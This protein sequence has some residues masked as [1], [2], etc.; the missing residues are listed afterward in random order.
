M[1][2][3]TREIIGYEIRD[4]KTGERVKNGNYSYAKRRVARN[5]AE[6]MNMTYGAHRYSAV[7]IF[8]IVVSESAE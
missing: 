1:A 8:S 2:T 6:R 5:R 4:G 7:P 3:Q